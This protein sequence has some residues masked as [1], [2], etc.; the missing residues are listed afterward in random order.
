MVA[1]KNILSV[2][3][4]T[5][6]EN[7]RLLGYETDQETLKRH[8]TTALD[9]GENVIL[10]YTYIDNNNIIIGGHEI[11]VV[12]YKRDISGKLIFVCNFKTYSSFITYPTLR[13]V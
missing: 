11:T 7:A 4:Q 5:V 1:D 12:D 9:M 6:D 10:G 3:Y 2:T 8:L 13:T